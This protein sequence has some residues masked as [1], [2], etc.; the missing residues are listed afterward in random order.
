MFQELEKANF[1]RPPTAEPPESVPEC[2]TFYNWADIVQINSTD[3]R[4]IH[5]RGIGDPSSSEACPYSTDAMA[6]NCSLAVECDTSAGQV[7]GRHGRNCFACTQ[8]CKELM[9]EDMRG[10]VDDLN[11]IF[12]VIIFGII[13]CMI[14][15]VQLIA[16]CKDVQDWNEY[17]ELAARTSG[18]V[19]D[20]EEQRMQNTLLQK[21]GMICNGGICVFGFFIV[22]VAIYI[23]STQSDVYFEAT[24]V[25]L[26]IG[27]AL[28]ATGCFL[29]FGTVQA[30]ALLLRIGNWLLMVFTF[31]LMMSSMFLSLCSG[32]IADIHKDIDDDWD[33][34][35]AALTVS[36]PKYCRPGDTPLTD[37]ECKD[38]FFEDLQAVVSV[39][40]TFTL[41]AILS[42]CKSMLHVCAFAAQFSYF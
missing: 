36:D 26:V 8:Q 16:I 20:F 32:T 21:I 19:D 17:M 9:V 40:F 25:V 27:L 37:D 7:A 13:G 6:T 29:V 4:G 14:F 35:S 18:K 5:L 11:Y 33:E 39:L 24:V 10:A 3:I 2:A 1:C 30:A 31:I 41:I 34:I 23:L 22:G 12:Y 15:N 38:K 28:A 42:M